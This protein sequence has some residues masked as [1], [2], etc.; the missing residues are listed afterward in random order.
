VWNKN[1]KLRKLS[2]DPTSSHRNHQMAPQPSTSNGTSSAST[3]PLTNGLMV[4]LTLVCHSHTKS[5]ENNNM[6]RAN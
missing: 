6:S 5:D 4:M 2:A 1:L 3:L